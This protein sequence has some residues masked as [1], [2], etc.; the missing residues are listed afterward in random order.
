MAFACLQLGEYL[1]ERPEV[2]TVTKDA[3]RGKV[4]IQDVI[5]A[6]CLHYGVTREHMMTNTRL[7]A[8][9]WP[10]QVAHY[11]AKQL[12]NRS[13]PD[14]GQRIGNKDHTT[15]MHS[16]RVV[17]DKCLRDNHLSEEINSLRNNLE[18]G[19]KISAQR[20]INML[21][22]LDA[23]VSLCPSLEVMDHPHRADIAARLHARLMALSGCSDISELTHLVQVLRSNAEDASLQLVREARTDSPIMPDDS[24]KI[25][26]SADDIL[27]AANEAFGIPIA[28]IMAPHISTTSPSAETRAL[29][30][31]MTALMSPHL[32]QSDL[33]AR[34]DVSK[35][36]LIGHVSNFIWRAGLRDKP[37]KCP[38]NPE[39]VRKISHVLACLQ[40]DGHSV[41]ATWLNPPDTVRKSY[42]LA[43][44]TLKR[45]IENL[46]DVSRSTQPEW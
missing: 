24:A 18:L 37:E 33:A 23:E 45:M 20:L 13:L 26:I 16:I 10:R 12:C 41:P 29:C 19:K 6:V 34:F 35:A 39:I 1:R 40:R 8:I 25:S 46:N 2:L 4:R 43:P 11:L 31:S 22:E 9:V 5:E 17:S 27:R 7:R 36:A 30:M 28:M 3:E 42:Q 21:E 15:V 44:E 38:R 32:S 14:I